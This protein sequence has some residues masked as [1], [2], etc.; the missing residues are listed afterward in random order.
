MKIALPF[1]TAALLLDIY[2]REMKTFAH[3]EV[4]ACTFI[5]ALFVIAK[6][7]KQPKD[8]TMDKQNMIYSCN[9]ILLNHKL[10][11]VLITSYHMNKP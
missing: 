7:W 6:W 10:N 3:A 1:D 8:P 5:I 9:G 2:S 11:E 4:C